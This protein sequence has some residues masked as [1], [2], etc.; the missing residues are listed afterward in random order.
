MSNEIEKEIQKEE[1][2]RMQK[3]N[4]LLDLEIELQKVVV[5]RERAAFNEE[6]AARKKDSSPLLGE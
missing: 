1:L 3:R 4:R 6:I 2:K 5:D